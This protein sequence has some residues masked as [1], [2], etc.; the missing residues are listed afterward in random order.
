[1]ENLYEG[2]GTRPYIHDIVGVR[3]FYV[4]GQSDEGY[5]VPQKTKDAPDMLDVENMC[6]ALGET[7]SV[8]VYFTTRIRNQKVELQ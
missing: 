3:P 8:V 6:A 4:E 5:T 7:Y 1:M 2:T